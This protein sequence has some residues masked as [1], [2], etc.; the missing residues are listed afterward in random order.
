MET[1]RKPLAVILGL[2]AFAVLFHFVLSPFYEDVVE[3]GDVW[4]VL[5]WFMALAVIVAL[6]LT[7]LAKRDAGTDSV[8][9]NTYIRVNV[10]FYAAAA[11]AILYFWNWSNE[12]VVGGGSEGEV[13]GIFWVVIDTLYVILMTR[14]SVHLWR[15]S[16]RKWCRC[17]AAH[18]VTS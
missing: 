15:D 4:N 5:N 9:T 17:R 8:D 2:T 13:N 18:A 10:G 16:S 3:S 6:V 1:L 7:Y 12:L 11:L 14:I